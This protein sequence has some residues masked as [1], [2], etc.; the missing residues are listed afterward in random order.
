MIGWRRA[1]VVER[2]TVEDILRL[3]GLPQPNRGGFIHCS[4]PLHRDVHPSAR[5]Q[6]SGRGVRR[7]GCGWRGGLLDV[8]VALGLAPDRASATR[9]LEGRRR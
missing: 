8:A 4:N 6:S 7:H 3:R 1:S 9:K 5:V 2:M